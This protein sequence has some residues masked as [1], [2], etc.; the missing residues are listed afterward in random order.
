MKA[1]VIFGL[2]A[3]LAA[4]QVAVPVSQIWKHEDILATGR[5]Y[6]FRTAPVDPYDAFRG[7]YVA[8]W[9]AGTVTSIRAGD[10]LG[11]RGAAYVGLEEGSDGF[12]RFKELSAT[13]PLAGDYLRVQYLWGNNTN[14]NFALPFDRFYMEE[15]AAPKAESAY[16]EFGNRRGQTNDHTYVVVR[17]KGGRGVIEDLFIKDKPVRSFL[18]EHRAASK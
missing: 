14:A 12:V 7:R 6:K 3:L 17:V 1:K 11:Y 8:L 9:F 10:E 15:T 13:P 18:K 16:R 4:V 5:A 2:F